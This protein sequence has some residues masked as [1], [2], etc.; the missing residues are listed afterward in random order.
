M[1]VLSSYRKIL[2]FI[3]LISLLFL[4]VTHIHHSKDG[5]WGYTYPVIAQ[6]RFDLSCPSGTQPFAALVTNNPQTGNLKANGC[7]DSTGL[8]T[9]NGLTSGASSPKGSTDSGSST[10]YLTDP[11]YQFPGTAQWSCQA[12]ITLNSN[13]VTLPANDRVFTGSQTRNAQVGD[14]IWGANAQCG[15]EN[16]IPIPTLILPQGTIT[17]V[18]SATQVHVSTTATANCTVIAKD[19]CVFVWGPDATTALQNAW[20]DTAFA[21]GTLILPAGGIIYQSPPNNTTSGC[22]GPAS[23]NDVGSSLT[24]EGQGGYVTMLLATPSMTFGN[25]NFSDP[26]GGQRRTFCCFG[27]ASFSPAPAAANLKSGFSIQFY[28]SFHDVFFLNYFPSST[29]QFTP[30]VASGVG[31][32]APTVYNNVFLNSGNSS[33][34]ISNGVGVF[35]NAIQNVNRCVTDNGA[36]QGSNYYAYNH[37]VLC[38]IQGAITM[39]GSSGASYSSNDTISCAAATSLPCINLNNTNQ[40]Y[41]AENLIMSMAG[42]TGPA[43]SCTSGSKCTVYSD[44]TGGSV[45]SASAGTSNAITNGGTFT[46]RNTTIASTGGAAISNSGTVLFKEGNVISTGGLTNTGT[47]Q[48]IPS[49]AGYVGSCTGVVTS[50]TTVGLYGLAQ[51]TVT[52]CTSTTVANGQVMAKPGSVYALYCTATAGNQASDA[53]TVVKNGV[54]QTMTCSLNAVTSCTDGTVAHQIA[55]VAGDILGIEVIGGTATTLANV[56]GLI[57]AQ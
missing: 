4:I 30:L 17:S 14:I 42:T 11:K 3:I 25:I 37:F 45:V 19:N 24:V 49:M 48:V 55:Y 52:S 29:Q 51:Q 41:Y 20:N 16:A 43:I 32:A 33:M 7:I 47:I 8:I 6:Q 13:I 12:G 9:F 57:V 18:D 38:G 56:K 2:S 44:T 46:L 21:C 40:N 10:I 28:G 35:N 1:Q 26:L 53:C 39:G 31:N 27:I 54:A 15:G 36:S 22:P 50:A 34:T 23:G 5:V